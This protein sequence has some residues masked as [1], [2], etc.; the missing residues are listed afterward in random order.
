MKEAT[1]AGRLNRSMF[2][3]NPRAFTAHGGCLFGSEG[4]CFV[5]LPLV[6]Q[7]STLAARGIAKMP[8]F[9]TR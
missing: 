1:P 8:L 7:R 9:N 3:S 5:H 4:V 6:K 2:V